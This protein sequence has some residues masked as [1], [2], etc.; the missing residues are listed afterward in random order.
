MYLEYN[1]IKTFN[2]LIDLINNYTFF[3]AII[4]GAIILGILLFINI[5]NDKTKY[6]ILI[7]NF[8]LI[9]SIVNYYGLNIFDGF[10]HYLNNMY[11]YFFNSI[12]FLSFINFLYF[13]DIINKKLIIPFYIISLINIIFSLFMTFYL[14][15]I[16]LLVLGNVY[17]IIKFGNIIYF[18]FL[19]LIVILQSLK[20]IK[21][22]NYDRKRNK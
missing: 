5:N 2:L 16:D 13:K 19:I 17:P 20:Y 6:I 4:I 8:L 22:S 10:N 11:S 14:K 9:I 12:L 21:R 3:K 1:I 7:I 15:N 18:I